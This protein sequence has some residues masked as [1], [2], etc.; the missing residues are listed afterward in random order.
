VTLTTR[1]RRR[2]PQPA[3]TAARQRPPRSRKAVAALLIVAAF[4]GGLWWSAS[5]QRVTTPPDTL[6]E[7]PARSA[8][9]FVDS[10]GVNIHLHYTDT[11]Y[12]AFD[13]IVRPRLVELGV[14]HVRDAVYTYDG[15]SGDT[16]VYRRMRRLGQDGIRFTLITSIE[17]ER[18]ERTD[19]SML[20]RVQRWTG[21]AVDAFEGANEPDLSGAAEWVTRTRDLQRDLWNAVTSDPTLGDV[22][23]IGPSAAWEPG[24]LGDVSAWT[25]YGN[26][27]PYPGGECP[28]CRDGDDQSYQSRMAAYGEPTG[29]DPLMATETGYHNAVVGEQDHRPV[30][31]RAAAAYLPRLLFEHFDRGITRSYLYELIDQRDDLDRTDREGN[32]GLL[33]NDGSRKPAFVA[34]RNLIRLLADPGPAFS[35]SPLRFELVDATPEV[36]HT[37]LQKRD[38]RHYIALWLREPSYDTDTRR[39]LDVQ[40]ERVTVTT[41]PMRRARL[42]IPGTS[43]DPAKQWPAGSSFAFDVAGEVVVLE[44]TP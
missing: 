28:A 27:H 15:V 17:T 11:V 7:H 12:S 13:T 42:F 8:A 10:I 40:P 36:G 44:L 20:G 25:D 6:P 14:R 18:S 32:F 35:P 2:A 41:A 1:P 43:S 39:D 19:L 3:S 4:C 37:V 34:V 29:N 24:A 31:E 21:G 9:D 5:R 26:W 30:S 23:V 33:R 22:D 16:F 38:G